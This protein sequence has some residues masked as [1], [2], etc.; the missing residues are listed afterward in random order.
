AKCFDGNEKIAA[1]I[2]GQAHW[3]LAGRERAWPDEN[4]ARSIRRES[5]DRLG[6]TVSCIEIA[7]G[8]ES[9]APALTR[10][11]AEDDPFSI[12]CELEDSAGPC[13]TSLIVRHD[14]GIARDVYGK[15]FKEKV[16]GAANGT[17]VVAQVEFQH[18]P[19]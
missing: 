19:N 6:A 5:V 8:V 12:W 13:G 9:Q 15:A 11:G 7:R 3:R 14:I 10:N 17:D 16:N 18:S 4:S 2:K 1:A